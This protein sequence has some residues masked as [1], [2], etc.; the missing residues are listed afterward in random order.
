MKGK[1][2]DDEFSIALLDKPPQKNS[3]VQFNEPNTLITI[4]L[5]ETISDR[6]VADAFSRFGKIIDIFY[7]RHKFCPQIGNAKR[8]IRL[9]PKDHDFMNIPQKIAFHGGVI[10]NVI[11]PEKVISCGKCNQKHSYVA[12]CNTA[13]DDKIDMEIVNSNQCI[14][15][16]PTPTN[17]PSVEEASTDGEISSTE[18][19]TSKEDERPRS[20]GEVTK[21][22]PALEPPV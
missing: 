16:S 15:Q 20:K 10:R 1:I 3:K 4:Y 18:D 11:Y 19:K 9:I 2:K 6:Q 12:G 5:P 14:V 21:T 17:L 22:D 7:G 13:T 8:H